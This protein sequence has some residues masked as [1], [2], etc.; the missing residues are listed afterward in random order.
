MKNV[1]F[2]GLC[3]IVLVFSHCGYPPAEERKIQLDDFFKYQTQ[4]SF[5]AKEDV[6]SIIA[7]EVCE[8]LEFVH[9]EKLQD[10]EAIVEGIK[11]DSVG[12]TMEMGFHMVCMLVQNMDRQGYPYSKVDSVI[13]VAKQRCPERYTMAE[14]YTTIMTERMNKVFSNDK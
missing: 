12:Y 4:K 7:D 2:L 10:E 11:K 8:C 14:N 6:V 13:A 3:F 1:W 9:L 5:T